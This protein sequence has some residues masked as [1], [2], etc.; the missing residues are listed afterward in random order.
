M[1]LMDRQAALTHLISLFGSPYFEGDGEGTDPET[2]FKCYGFFRYAFRL[3][4]IGIQDDFALAVL[5]FFQIFCPPVPW[6]AAYF[7]ETSVDRH[8]GIVI[9]NGRVLQCSRETNGVASVR[10][11]VTVERRSFWRHKELTIDGRPVIEAPVAGPR[12]SLIAL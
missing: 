10:L 7:R 4:G 5:D 11:D 2:G 1:N 9:D 3:I 6:D 12:S 8:I